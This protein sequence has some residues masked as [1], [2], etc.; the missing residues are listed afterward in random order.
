MS[1][2]FIEMKLGASSESPLVNGYVVF[3]VSGKV[4]VNFRLTNISLN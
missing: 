4:R 3:S 2:A 1:V